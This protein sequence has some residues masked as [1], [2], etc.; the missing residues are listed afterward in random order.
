MLGVPLTNL[1][2]KADFPVAS[3]PADAYRT[4]VFGDSHTVSVRNQASYAEV[5]QA[6]LRAIGKALADR[7]RPIVF[8]D[9]K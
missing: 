9:R 6:L 5:L 7:G 4:V 1:D 8:E 3:K 2:D